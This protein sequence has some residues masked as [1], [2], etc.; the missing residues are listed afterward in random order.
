MGELLANLMAEVVNKMVE[1][2][3]NTMD[4]MDEHRARV[5]WDQLKG[6]RPLMAT[7]SS[8]GRGEGASWSV[9][10]IRL[11]I[12]MGPLAITLLVLDFLKSSLAM[13]HLAI[14]LLAMSSLVIISLALCSLA[15]RSLG[16]G[17]LAVDLLATGLLAMDPLAIDSM[18]WTMATS[19]RAVSRMARERLSSFAKGVLATMNRGELS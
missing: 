5:A 18:P 13:G 16:L 11:A 6:S 10:I 15:I 17:P 19:S 3:A 1:A 8:Q 2:T 7:L 4:V 14:N 9:G 12:S